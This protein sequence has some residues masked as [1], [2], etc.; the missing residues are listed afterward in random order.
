MFTEEI[1]IYA[2]GSLLCSFLTS[3]YLVPT[4]KEIG[5]S[6]QLM[7]TPNNRSSH[8]QSTASLGGIVFFITFLFSFCISNQ[9]D[10]FNISTS[11]LPGVTVLFFMGLKDDLVGLSPKIKFIGQI[12]AC[13][14]VLNHTNFKIDNFHGFFGLINMPLWLIMPLALLTMIAVINAYNLIDGIDGLAASISTLGLAFFSICFFWIGDYF[15]ALTA[16]AMIGALLGFLLYNLSESKKIFMGDTGSLVIGFLIAVMSIRLLALD[17][18]L[19]TLPFDHKYIPILTVIIIFIP[20]YDVVRVFTIRLLQKRSPFSADRFHVHHIMID[21]L[22]WSHRRTAFAISCL[23]FLIIT[24]G[25]ALILGDFGFVSI[26]IFSSLTVLFITLTLN[27]W[28]AEIEL[29]KGADS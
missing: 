9:F 25:L 10:E 2:L 24:C 28:S 19:N 22:E 27:K 6:K 29:K 26:G 8:T 20:I 18:E 11:I 17:S 4:V 16:V 15:L 1:P 5:H 12:M 3:A 23:N 13:L 14:I 7:D 21:K